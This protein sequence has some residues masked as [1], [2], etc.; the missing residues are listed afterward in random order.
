MCDIL[1][2]KASSASSA[3]SLSGVADVPVFVTSECC[4]LAASWVSGD[5]DGDVRDPMSLCMAR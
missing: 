5:G 2:W 3:E 4:V 1:A